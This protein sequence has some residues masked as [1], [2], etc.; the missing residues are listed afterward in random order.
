MLIINR[1][2]AYQGNIQVKKI[3][4]CS[5]FLPAMFLHS[6]E[7]TKVQAAREAQKTHLF[8]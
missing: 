5:Y 7:P 2:C 6:R 1:A 8:S 3:L 4:I